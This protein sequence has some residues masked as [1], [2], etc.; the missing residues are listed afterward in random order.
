MFTE[1]AKNFLLSMWLQC[2]LTEA[3]VEDAYQKA[4]I[5][6]EERDEILNTPRNC[7]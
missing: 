7:P 4:K 5:T 2:R 6:I 1:A 3:Q